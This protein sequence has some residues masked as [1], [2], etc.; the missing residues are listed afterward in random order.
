MKKYKGASPND[1]TDCYK[2]VF[3]LINLTFADFFTFGPVTATR[4]H[5]AF[6]FTER[7]VGPWNSLPVSVDGECVLYRFGFTL[8]SILFRADIRALLCLSVLFNISD[9]VRPILCCIAMRFMLVLAIKCIIIITIRVFAYQADF[10]SL[11]SRLHGIHR[12]LY[13]LYQ[14]GR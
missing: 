9:H 13:D 4:S 3:G 14:R 5:K 12:R 1:Y 6:F 2:I 7:V 8:I 10:Y 11:L